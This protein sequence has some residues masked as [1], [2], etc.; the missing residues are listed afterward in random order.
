MADP[1][2]GVALVVDLAPRVIK[3]VIDV[4][5]ASRDRQ[6]LLAEIVGAAGVLSTLKLALDKADG[7]DEWAKEVIKV[8]G[9]E[10]AVAGVLSVLQEL[11]GKLDEPEKRSGRIK[12]ALAWPF[13]SK[14]VEKMVEKL[15][16]YKQQILMALQLQAFRDTSALNGELKAMKLD[17]EQILANTTVTLQQSRRE[18]YSKLMAWLSTFD[19]AK[20]HKAASRT[21]T[22]GTAEW[23]LD[24]PTFK[25]WYDGSANVLICSG[26]P[27][28]GK[29][30][31]ASCV[32]DHIQERVLA[33]PFA[34]QETGLAYVYLDYKQRADMTHGVIVASLVKQ[35]I[36]NEAHFRRLEAMYTA[37]KDSKDNSPSAED[38]ER[39]LLDLIDDYE[40]V[41]LVIDAFDEMNS[42]DAQEELTKFLLDL[43]STS[44]Q[45]KIMITSRSRPTSLQDLGD[46]VFQELSASASDIKTYVQ[47]RMQ[48][49]RRFQRQISDDENFRAHVKDTIIDRCKGMFLL[50][51]LHCDALAR[52]RTRADF[53]DTLGNLPSGVNGLRQTYL[54]AVGRIRSQE[55]QDIH[56]AESILAWV[57]FSARALKVEELRSALAVDPHKKDEDDFNERRLLPRE[58]IEY[59]CAGLVIID[60]N[61]EEVRLV[62]HT[63]QEFFDQQK[64]ILLA[65][66]RQTIGLACIKFLTYKRFDRDCKTMDEL[67]KLKKAN[68]FL[69]YAVEHLGRHSLDAGERGIEYTFALFRRPY[70][71]NCLNEVRLNMANQHNGI[72][73][74]PLTT[75]VE[76]KLVEVTKRLL[77]DEGNMPH[78]NWKVADPNICGVAWRYPTHEAG[79]SRQN[80]LV[81]IF[82]NTGKVDLSKTDRIGNTVHHACSVGH[83]DGGLKTALAKHKRNINHR[84]A[85]GNTALHDA[86]NFNSARCIPVLLEAGANVCINNGARKSPM[87]EAADRNRLNF[88]KQLCVAHKSNYSWQDERGASPL[89]MCVTLGLFSEA[90]AILK[91]RPDTI[92]LLNDRNMTPL[93]DAGEFDRP[94]CAKILLEHGADIHALDKW[95]RTPLYAAVEK[96]KPKMV[97]FLID[98]GADPTMDKHPKAMAHV[99]GKRHADI[100]KAL[101]THPK[102]NYRGVDP[103]N[104]WNALHHAAYSN[105]PS[106][107]AIFLERDAKEGYPLVREGNDIGETPVHAAAKNSIG[108]M[109]LFL[110][111]PAAVEM[112]F[113]KSDRGKTKGSSGATPVELAERHGR[114]DIMALLRPFVEE[115]KRA[116]DIAKEKAAA[117]AGS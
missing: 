71:L 59:L 79:Y 58:D 61:N 73:C 67:R 15:S 100:A 11:K 6:A 33:S 55:A 86:V 47:H 114:K 37:R 3:Y 40:T 18:R 28:N 17:Q 81:E 14:D 46:T 92:K 110:Q 51:R 64:N 82:L 9:V 104:S 88:V 44:T 112:L 102:F 35:L 23:L 39:I 19:Y 111:I 60:P 96:D 56:Y 31:I 116:E 48:T 65:D 34:A 91:E 68:P 74:S 20:R 4:K 43:Q 42:S 7:A 5:D 117:D 107:A 115:R 54:E 72:V 12:E 53:E 90:L 32:I 49:E 69:Q 24:A 113:V 101:L 109:K 36:V 10:D 66:A 84:N 8:D 63:T 57:C 25:Q 62:H 80:A 108:T 89:H 50:A 77:K 99:A 22:P 13:K 95:G 27:G 93:H 2:S 29:T 103:G 16:R 21:R 94:D 87:H 41:Y 78:C 106:A 76:Y 45:V 75:A 52:S 26:G 85:N 98:A 70:N 105:V 38:L 97:R 83:C 1:F 30:V